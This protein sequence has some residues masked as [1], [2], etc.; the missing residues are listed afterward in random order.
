MNWII[1]NNQDLENGCHKDI[2]MTTSEVQSNSADVCFISRD[3]R[4]NWVRYS[5]ITMWSQKKQVK[6]TT[7]LWFDKDPKNMMDKL[8]TKLSSSSECLNCTCDL[9][10]EINNL[11]KITNWPRGN[12]SRKLCSILPNSTF[13]EFGAKFNLFY[14]ITCIFICT[15][16][17]QIL[18]CTLQGRP[19]MPIKLHI[20][21]CTSIYFP[22][23]I[24]V[25]HFYCK[26]LHFLTN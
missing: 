20:I 7:D 17:P 3:K 8:S 13:L 14:N 1:C 16:E 2:G 6:P 24:L 25:N 23:Y 5:I 12:E 22:L 4:G 11:E 18:I 21:T 19:C 10:I 15:L 9:R 26:L